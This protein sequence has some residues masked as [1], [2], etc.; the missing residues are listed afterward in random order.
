MSGITRDQEDEGDERMWKRDRADK[1]GI[2]RE[3]GGW[4]G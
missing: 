2:K 1:R 3:Q 4:K